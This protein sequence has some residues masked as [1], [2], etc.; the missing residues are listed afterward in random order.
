MG[1]G[2]RVAAPAEGNSD[3]TLR[4]LAS[5]MFRESRGLMEDL[6]VGDGLRRNAKGYAIW[7]ETVRPVLFA[8]LS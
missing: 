2:Q 5:L 6:L 7:T 4:G 8:D 3:V 1:C